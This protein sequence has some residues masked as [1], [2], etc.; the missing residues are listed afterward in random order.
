MVSEQTFDCP[1]G[2]VADHRPFL[3]FYDEECPVCRASVRGIL[4]L[5]PRSTIRAVGLRS[6]LADRLLPD[7]PLHQRLQAF[8]LLG[9]DGRHWKGPDALPPLLERLRLRPAASLLRRSPLAYRT[10][11]SAYHWVSRHRGRLARFV[12]KSWGRPVPGEEP[13]E[14]PV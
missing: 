10:A 13:P 6:K 11:S 5:A 1:G 9:P 4:R 7:E 14:G 12:P 3:L 8:H 2:D